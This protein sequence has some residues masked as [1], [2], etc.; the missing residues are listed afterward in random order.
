[1]STVYHIVPGVRGV[2][3][4]IDI[5]AESELPVSLFFLCFVSF[6]WI[7]FVFSTTVMCWLLDCSA[8]TMRQGPAS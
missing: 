2:H 7:P 1:M 4:R 5:L 6:D 8:V 3:H